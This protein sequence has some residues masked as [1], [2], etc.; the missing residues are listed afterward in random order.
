MNTAEIIYDKVR[1]LDKKIFGSVENHILRSL[2]GCILTVAIV[3]Q[4]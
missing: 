1:M 3:K 2:S 4:M